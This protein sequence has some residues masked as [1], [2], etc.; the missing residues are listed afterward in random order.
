MLNKLQLNKITNYALLSQGSLILFGLLNV[1]IN[2]IS[3]SPSDLG[4]YYSLAALL[5]VQQFINGGVL[6]NYLALIV[7]L[8]S[9]KTVRFQKYISYIFNYFFFLSPVIF[10]ICFS[11]TRIII[12]D[13]DFLIAILF[14]LS[15]ALDVLTVWFYPSL[16]GLGKLKKFYLLR[17]IVSL[18]SYTVS[19]YV[20][21]T[22]N[23]LMGLVCFVFISSFLK[24]IFAYSI[25]FKYIKIGFSNLKQPKE[26]VL[27]AKKIRI[28]YYAG[29]IHKLS[30]YPIINTSLGLEVSGVFGVA[31]S[32]YN[33]VS[34]LFRELI[35][36]N[37]KKY[38]LLSL[39]SSKLLF[40]SFRKDL[41]LV[42]LLYVFF[43]SLVLILIFLYPKL[44]DVKD[45]YLI[46]ILSFI[47]HIS[48]F[49]YGQLSHLHRIAGKEPTSMWT[50][51]YTII[52]FL[53]LFLSLEISQF[54]NLVSVLTLSILLLPSIYYTRA[55]NTN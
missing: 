48:W 11:Y 46:M 18:L 33:S 15:S 38:G 52:F 20:V 26:F 3:L 14:S 36:K 10:F 23:S 1:Y 51:V 17:I 29:L 34:T 43:I 54:F 30:L 50:S 37:F 16:E 49:N 22:Y 7:K 42:N 53:V 24:I 44:I 32:I 40:K 5:I 27:L 55:Y 4:L 28:T 39:E 35:R 2:T 19:W 6:A 45:L 31:S 8:K 12:T 47:Y 13:V 25:F 41:L 9:Y 21:Y